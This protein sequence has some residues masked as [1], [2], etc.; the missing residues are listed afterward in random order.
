M[1]FFM[2]SVFAIAAFATSVLA[3]ENPI[4]HP[5]SNTPMTAGE[6]YD[7]TWTPTNNNL[8]KLTLRKGPSGN[9]KDILIIVGD[10][11]NSG[12][13]TWTP[14]PDLPAGK[15]YAVMI[16]DKAGNINYTPLIELK[17]AT[18]EASS[19]YS[20]YVAPSSTKAASSTKEASS[21]KDA[22]STTETPSVTTTEA[23]KTTVMTVVQG[24]S[25]T[26]VTS[27]M[28]S[29]GTITTGLYGNSTRSTSTRSS[30]PTSDE[31]STPTDTVISTGAAAGLLK[32]PLALVVCLIGAVV[33]LN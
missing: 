26:M 3:G 27:V 1:R 8:I 11:T 10:Y 12:K 2:S 19:A 30:K 22:A 28:S 32:S 13:F 6:P 4:I 33:Y 14:N 7:I 24:N 9:L 16:T 15:D 25:T 21:A 29:N 23:P 18:P 31:T 20:S 5:D 17:A